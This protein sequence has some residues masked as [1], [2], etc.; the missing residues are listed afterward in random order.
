M[1]RHI[2]RLLER[3]ELSSAAASRTELFSA[4]ILLVHPKDELTDVLLL[5]SDKPTMSVPATPEEVE[6]VR[7][8]LE[9]R[10]AIR[11]EIE[12]KS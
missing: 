5:E 7:A 1:N 3:L 9:R 10:R 12:A 11:L 2:S 8:G 4:R 6:R